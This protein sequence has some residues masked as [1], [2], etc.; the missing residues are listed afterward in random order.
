[1]TRIKLKSNTIYAGEAKAAR[2]IYSTDADPGIRR[3]RSGRGFRYRGPSGNVIQQP[4]LLTRIRNLAIP[5]AWRDVWISPRPRGHI[6]A[7]GRDARGRKQY[8][9]HAEWHQ[10]RDIIKYERL[11][12]FGQRL[13][14]IRRKIRRD[15]NLAGFPKDK[16]LATVAQLLDVTHIRVGNAEYA[17]SNKSYGLTT[18]RNRHAQVRGTRVIFQFT[19]KSGVQ[20]AVE[21]HDPRLAR[22]IKACQELPGQKLFQY[23]DERGRRQSVTSCQINDYLRE[24]AGCEVTAKDFRTW[25]GTVHAAAALAKLT[26]G[27]VQSATRRA[28]TEVIGE[29]AKALGNTKTV[30]RKAYIHPSVFEAFA[31]SQLSLAFC[32]RYKNVIRGLSSD[33]RSVLGFLQGL[34]KK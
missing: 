1:M 25:A 7:T 11:L 15:L 6:Q 14:V 26:P 13:P 20:H 12:D 2:L 21:L 5:P 29:V 22:I 30:C 10:R 27:E 28:I 23:I 34:A 19:G 33:E 16:V 31:A 4:A 3:L 24:A 17:R 9:Y 8:I 32:R 18:F